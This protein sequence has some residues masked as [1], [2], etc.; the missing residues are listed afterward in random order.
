MSGA[1]TSPV[2]AL[3]AYAA[4]IVAAAPTFTREQLEKIGAVLDQGPTTVPDAARR[5]S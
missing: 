4:R 3:D 1:E 5:A 2:D